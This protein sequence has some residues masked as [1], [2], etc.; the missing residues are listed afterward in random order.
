MIDNERDFDNQFFR[1][2]T[3]SLARTLS[4]RVRWINKFEDSN[5][6]VFLPIYTSLTG[7]ERFCLDAFV[8]DVVDKRVMLNTDQFQR[9]VITY[10]GFRAKAEE[11]ANPNQ[12]LSKK[13][14]IDDQLRKV[15]SK[16]K[17]IP[18]TVNYTV[19]IQLATNNEVDKVCQKIL[20]AFFN[21]YKF[22]MD[23]FGLTINCLMTLPDLTIEIPK[24]IKMDTERKKTISFT[25]AVDTYYP[26]FRISTDDITPCDND[27]DFDWENL[28]FPRPTVD[29]NQSIKNYNQAYGVTNIAGG[30]K[31]AEV[32]GMTVIRKVYYLNFL[33][34]LDNSGNTMAERNGNPKNW[35]KEDL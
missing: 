5:I 25:M 15:V 35:N 20:D 18:V 27:A 16:V 17:A 28:D 33:S 19:D 23:Y 14:K 7:D 34:S 1:S 24:E 29:F 8:D 2:V 10:N 30:D 11:F 12:Y 9:G 31:G 4:K 22:N 32:E 6:R 26:S 21:Y 3:V 13:V